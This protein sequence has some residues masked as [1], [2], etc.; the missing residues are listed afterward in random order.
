M[1]EGLAMLSKKQFKTYAGLRE[2]T[3]NNIIQGAPEV[4]EKLEL[5]GTA[6]GFLF[7]MPDVLFSEII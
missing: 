2:H 5:G 6:F 3:D 1:K 7:L 4:Q